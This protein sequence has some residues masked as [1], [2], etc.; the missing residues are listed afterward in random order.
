MRCLSRTSP[1]PMTSTR[2]SA[3]VEIS[4]RDRRAPSTLTC[5]A[6]VV[7]HLRELAVRDAMFVHLSMLAAQ[8][9]D[10][11]LSWEQT[12]EFS[13][14]GETIVMRQTRGRGIHKPRQ[15]TAALSITT[16]F[17]GF[18][19]QPPYLDAM[20]EDGHPRYKYEGT[21][22][23]LASNRALRAA[24]GLKLPVAYFKGVRPHV[25]DPVCPVY[26]AGEEPL[27]H[28]FIL[29]FSRSEVGLDFSSLTAPEKVYAARMT[30]QRLHQ[31][32]FRENVLHAYS[33]RCAV[34]RLRH[35]ELLDAAHITGDAEDGGDPVVPNGMALCKIHHAAFD[36]HFLGITPNHEVRINQ[37]LLDEVDGPMLKHGLQ[38][39][40]GTTI[41]A[42]R[43]PFARPDPLGLEERY[44]N[45]L[46]AS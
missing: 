23:N 31:P 5:L 33:S 42:P 1:S 2:C 7:D 39:M 19:R 36:R 40:H 30:K 29:S 21:D 34:C 24:M 16:A 43:S 9:N 41:T 35:A 3:V 38:E 13:F 15:L 20:G 11:Y 46:Q 14:D 27:Q 26:I 8:S 6:V 22:P 44:A 12:G 45:F 17:T 25:Y 18:G 28:E 10:G 32:L 37:R 4:N